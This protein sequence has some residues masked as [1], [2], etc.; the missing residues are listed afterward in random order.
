MKRIAVFNCKGGVGKTTTALNL[1]AAVEKSGGKSRLVDLDPQAHLT[2]VF[3]SM[4]RNA[5]MSTFALYTNTSS[6]QSLERNLPNIGNL[7]PA[8]GNLMKADSVFGKGPSALNRLRMSL[9]AA[10]LVDPRTT[11][12]DCCPFLG[13]LSISAIFVAD[14]V[15]V[16]V[17]ADFMSMQ[18]AH[19]ISH[20]LDALQ[21]VLK[22]RVSRRFLLTRY[23]RRRKMCQEVRQRLMDTYPEEVCETLIHENTAIATSPSLQKDIFSYQP[24]GPGATEYQALYEE[25]LGHAFI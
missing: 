3:N 9:D 17:S 23:D 22:H 25:L 1:A 11:L 15:L 13:V 8:H 21:P 2:R 19:Q 4:P 14:L 7:V 18:G 20:A 12:I 6:V 10:D 24:T 5:D 16:P